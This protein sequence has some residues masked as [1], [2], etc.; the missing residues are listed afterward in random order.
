MP[1]S[2]PGAPAGSTG[3]GPAGASH[4]RLRVRSPRE[5]HGQGDDPRLCC[6]RPQRG[7]GEADDHWQSSSHPGEHRRTAPG[8]T[9]SARRTAKARPPDPRGGSGGRFP[10]HNMTYQSIRGM[11][12]MLRPRVHWRDV[13]RCSDLP[14]SPHL[15]IDR[16]RSVDS[17]PRPSRPSIPSA[18]WSPASAPTHHVAS[19]IAPVGSPARSEG[20]QAPHGCHNFADPHLVPHPARIE[21]R[22]DRDV[23]PRWAVVPR[24]VRY[25]R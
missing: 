18:M 4:G 20:V 7:H 14:H 16:L 13:S 12:G 10:R 21:A 3:R 24:K 6:P 9:R 8:L 5:S 15:E 17:T 11:P 2:Q 1:A 25:L 22:R 23:A 19:V